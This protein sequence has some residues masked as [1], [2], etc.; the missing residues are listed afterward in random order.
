MDNLANLPP[1]VLLVLAVLVAV[2]LVLLLLVPFMI[3]SIRNSTR[4]ANLQLEQLNQRVDTLIALLD[5]TDAPG[6]RPSEPRPHLAERTRK[7]PTIS[8]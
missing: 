8:S 7:E 4:K 1:V 5:R 2:W 3:E 6:V